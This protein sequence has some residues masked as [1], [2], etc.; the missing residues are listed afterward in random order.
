MGIMPM[1][2][3]ASAVISTGRIR[4]APAR[5]RPRPEPCPLF[6]KIAR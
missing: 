1:I 4:V 2:I 3:I 6:F 5:V